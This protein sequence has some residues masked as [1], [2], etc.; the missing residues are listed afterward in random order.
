MLALA[1]N[2]SFGADRYTALWSDGSRSSAPEILDWSGATGRPRLNDRLLFDT[3]NPARWV[4]DN[5]LKLEPR[6]TA[7]VEFIGGD[8]LPGKVVGFAAGS[9]IAYESLPPHLLV[10]PG[11]RIDLPGMRGREHLRVLP[12][13]IRRVV[14]KTG[15]ERRYQPGTAFLADG[16]RLSYRSLRWGATGVRLLTE[17]GPQ[18]VALADLAEIHLPSRDP[19][20]LYAGQL[21]V[22]DPSG[23]SRLLRIETPEGLRATTSLDRI[24]PRAEGDAANPDTWQFAFQPAWTLDAMFVEH[25]RIALRRLLS[26]TRAPLDWLEPSASR[27]HGALSSAWEHF[28]SD[29]NVQGGPL[30]CGGQPF[31]WGF[32]VHA[33]HELEFE[34]PDMARA[35][36]T[37][38]GLDQLAGSGGCAR[39]LIYVFTGRPSNTDLAQLQPAYR[40]DLLIGS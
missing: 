27:H 7:F 32:G 40:S 39:G 15:E 22:L 13:M 1:C 29:A 30:A 4:R 18:T 11:L 9:A 19:W 20:E 33:R 14:W 16:R 26:A 37:W 31:D 2:A 10:E 25:R 38:L 28:E 34:L 5:S 21:A 24:R 3:R 6:P 23:K 35:F 36:R 12:D 8:L 17:N